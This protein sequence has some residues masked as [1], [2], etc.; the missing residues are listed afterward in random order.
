MLNDLDQEMIAATVRN[1]TMEVFSTMLCLD[2]TAGETFAEV[3][4]SDGAEGVM[5]FIGL[6]GRCT[7]AGSLRCS[8]EAACKL[9]SAFLMSEFE[10]VDGDVLDAIGELT[11]MIVGN[12]KTHLEDKLGA[13][14][15]SIPTVIHGRNFTARSSSREEWM[16]VPFE[17]AGGRVDVKVCL[18]AVEEESSVKA[19]S[20]HEFVLNGARS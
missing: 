14:S 3:H 15:L 13:I 16:G 4:A 20:Q 5:S 12:L 6:A 1:V 19:G 18:R 9:A 8:S 10:A 17:W 2:V 11:N 7:G